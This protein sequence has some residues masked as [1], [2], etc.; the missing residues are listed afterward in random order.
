M[1]NSIFS[2]IFKKSDKFTF[3]LLNA[4][5]EKAI[6]HL[7]LLKPGTLISWQRRFI[8]N[9]WTYKHNSPGRKPII[10][11]IKKLIFEMKQENYILEC[12]KIA[13]ELR[14]LNIYIHYTTVNKIIQTF[15]KQDL[16]SRM[17]H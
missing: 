11:D 9:F 12:K 7:T 3:V 2:T 8:K 10:R 1:F 4:F 15:R 16:F 5:S 14:K 17:A 6:G 13:H